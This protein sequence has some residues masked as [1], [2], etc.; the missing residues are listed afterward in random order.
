MLCKLP[1]LKTIKNFLHT[2]YS[3][4]YSSTVVQVVLD[5][6]DVYNTCATFQTTLQNINSRNCFKEKI[7]QYVFGT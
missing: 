5:L 1:I 7:G 4:K 6:F 2:K 3:T